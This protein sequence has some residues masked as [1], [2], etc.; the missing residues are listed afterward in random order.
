MP[1]CP[2][3]VPNWDLSVVLE[4]LLG[5]PFEPLESAPEQILTLKVALC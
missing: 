4:E 5:P 3:S 1:E 2:I